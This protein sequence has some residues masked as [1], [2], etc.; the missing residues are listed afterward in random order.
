MNSLQFLHKH[1][2]FPKDTYEAYH[3][4]LGLYL[5]Y[6]VEGMRQAEAIED[7]L[8]FD[9]AEASVILEN[10][11]ISIEVIKD[12]RKNLNYEF[13]AFDLAETVT[14]EGCQLKKGKVVGSHSAAVKIARM[15]INNY[16]NGSGNTFTYEVGVYILF[17][18][19]E[20][21]SYDFLINRSSETAGTGTKN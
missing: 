3:M 16:L 12:Y 6:M 18:L 13:T 14:M 20:E 17:L 21:V 5:L 11:S 7:G 10:L 19:N 9:E 2:I 1:G 4:S 8:V 15:W